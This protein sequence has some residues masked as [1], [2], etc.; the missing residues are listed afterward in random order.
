MIL[1]FTR[2]IKNLEI[3]HKV[4]SSILVLFSFIFMLNGYR[5]MNY[6][7]QLVAIIMLGLSSIIYTFSKSKMFS[8]FIISFFVFLVNRPI[9]DMLKGEK[10]WLSNYFMN[11]Y[12]NSYLNSALMIIYIALG[13]LLIGKIV[14]SSSFSVGD[15]FSI[16]V[17]EN[18]KARFVPVQ[19]KFNK[20]LKIKVDK[21]TLF[22]FLFIIYCLTYI[23]VMYA[24]IDKLLFMNGRMY[25]EYYLDYEVT[26]SMLITFM[27]RFNIYFL[28]F[29][30]ALLPD[31][32][33]SFSLLLLNVS[34]HVPTLILGQRGS[35]MLAIL[36]A[37]IYFLLRNELNRD[38]R[39]ITKKEIFFIVFL[40]LI[41]VVLLSAINDIRH[42]YDFSLLK[43]T[44]IFSNFLYKLGVTFNTHVYGI[45]NEFMIKDLTGSTNYLFGEILNNIRDNPIS[46]LIFG[47]L[48][49]YP[50]GNSF[51]KAVGGYWFS[52]ILA[53][54]SHP[55]YL[56]GFGYGTSYLTEAY[57]TYGIVGVV[58]VNILL[59]H[60]LTKL[61]K[62]LTANYFKRIIAMLLLYNIFYIPRQPFTSF[63]SF[64]V[65][66]YFIVALIILTLIITLSNSH[67]VDRL[68]YRFSSIIKRK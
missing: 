51:E 8:I 5:T 17:K 59:G 16:S 19:I 10:W 46:N 37:I 52:H 45:Q 23:F 24:E 67:Y 3:N 34:L 11:N 62:S 55:R 39:W 57:H 35:F 36:F 32:R 27:A 33:R 30:L 66:P 65:K 31:K 28:M 15:K 2:M 18:L 20:Y 21:K 60:L 43:I 25:Q 58:S 41:L 29:L 7:T 14:S 50:I 42:G 49:N 44:D 22:L 4:I 63:F 64:F 53:Y 1:K 68:I 6:N 47:N 13:S 40:G 61:D 56:E 54:V 48:E 12:D 9:I 26:Y 38:E